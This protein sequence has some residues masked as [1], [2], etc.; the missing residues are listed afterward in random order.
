MD[1]GEVGGAPARVGGGAARVAR[2]E[3]RTI[4]GS[5][6]LPSGDMGGGLPASGV[7]LTASI[8]DET[9]L[10]PPTSLACLDSA[11]ASCTCPCV[12]V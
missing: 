11:R 4:A 12:K 10:P 8:R 2:R 9:S 1:G 3:F 5:S 7:G 6:L